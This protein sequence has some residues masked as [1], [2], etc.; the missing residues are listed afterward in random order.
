MSA[1]GARIPRLEIREKVTGRAAYIADLARPNMLHGAILTSP[2]PHARILGYD[3]EEARALAGV[4]AVITGDDVG[5]GL[6]GA[7]IKDEPAIAK[8]K[9]RYVGEAV[10]A[11]AA[12]DEQTARAALGLIRVD[13]EELPALLTPEDA[14]APGAAPIHENLADYF[15]VFDAQCEGNQMSRTEIVEGDVEAGFAEADVIVE[16][17]FETQAQNHLAIELPW[18]RHHDLLYIYGLDRI[19][20]I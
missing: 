18:S 20:I 14:L 3:A 6:M 15:K 16:G 9:V 17:D 10:A 2:Y 13:Y 12:D 8:G 7:F 11:V 1:V 4:H 19:L 5:D